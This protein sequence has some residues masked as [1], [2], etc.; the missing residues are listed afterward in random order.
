MDGMENGVQGQGESTPQEPTVTKPQD[1]ATPAQKQAE[2]TEKRPEVS[3]DE[4]GNLSIG[5]AMF[6]EF[7]TAGEEP[8]NDDTPE[9]E[10]QPTEEPTLYKVK[11]NG[12]E[13]EVTLQELLDGYSRTAD[14]TNK[15]QK[16]GEERRQLESE[17]AAITEQMELINL[18]TRFGV[19]ISNEM[20]QQIS[21]QADSIIRQQFGTDADSLS[22]D[23]Q[24]ARSVIMNQLTHQYSEQVKAT[25]RLQRTEQI[26]RQSEPNFDKIQ[27]LALQI[28]QTEMSHAQFMMLQQ[29]QAAGNPIPIV[30][31]FDIARQRFYEKAQGQNVQPQTATQQPAPMQPQKPKA[32]EPPKTE[33][34]GRATIQQPKQPKFDLDGFSRMSAQEQVSALIK[35]GFVS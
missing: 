25:Q 9:P 14:Y 12:E 7:A 10:E 35:C 34:A 18:Q 20:R 30:N 23:V 1:A 15:T 5:D 16:L 26:L 24:D 4:E 33:S 22:Q 27:Q 28:A 21:A 11:V 19:P 13:Q 29:A 2:E 17:K 31:L 32:P 6:G 3:I 8:T